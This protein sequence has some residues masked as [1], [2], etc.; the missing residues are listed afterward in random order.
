MSAPLRKRLDWLRRREMMRWAR[1]GHFLRRSASSVGADLLTELLK[2]CKAQEGG[3]QRA[4]GT[5]S[6]ETSRTCWSATFRRIAV[7]A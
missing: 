2:V 4:Q 1:S 5:G 6:S 3:S 7:A